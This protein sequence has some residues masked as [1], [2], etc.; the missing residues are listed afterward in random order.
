M[1]SSQSESS[2][3]ISQCAKLGRLLRRLT[4]SNLSHQ[5]LTLLLEQFDFDAFRS[6]EV[7]VRKLSSVYVST[8]LHLLFTAPKSEAIFDS[9]PMLVRTPLLCRGL[10]IYLSPSPLG[11]EPQVE[12]RFLSSHLSKR[13]GV[14]FNYA[15]AA[16]SKQEQQLVL[17]VG[18]CKVLESLGSARILDFLPDPTDTCIFVYSQQGSQLQ[19]PCLEF[20][21]VEQLGSEAGEGP[22]SVELAAL[23]TSH[24]KDIF[25]QSAARLSLFSVHSRPLTPKQLSHQPKSVP[26]S[27]QLPSEKYTGSVCADKTP[28]LTSRSSSK[29]TP[30][31]QIRLSAGL[32]SNPKSRDSSSVC[33]AAFVQQLPERETSIKPKP[34][35]FV[36]L[37]AKL[38]PSREPKA[39]HSAVLFEPSTVNP[40]SFQPFKESTG[41]LQPKSSPTILISTKKEPL[42]NA[43]FKSTKLRPH[44]SAAHTQCLPGLPRQH[45]PDQTLSDSRRP[46]A[47][48]GRISLLRPNMSRP[49]AIDSLPMSAQSSARQ[50]SKSSQTRSAT[51]PIRTR[52]RS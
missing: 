48:V 33:R 1:S 35:F 30:K 28:G 40:L 50:G 26:S 9:S 11:A 18:L 7:H 41:H 2:Q 10:F 25:S 36:Q 43:P 38:R 42:A 51:S 3:L 5:D 21:H 34:A 24:I 46:G 14:L 47:S 52:K 45:K 15:V 22:R 4:A 37:R 8:L 29:R 32:P 12:Q 44:R 31:F 39:D 27:D 23:F 19:V 49:A 6:P 17:G 16:V 13:D 20:V